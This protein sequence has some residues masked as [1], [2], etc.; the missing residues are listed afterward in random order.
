MRTKLNG[1]LTLL[2]ALIVHITYAQEKTVSGTVTDQS[3]LP[4]PG[5]NIVVQGTT[6]GTQSDFDGNYSITASVG[7]NLLFTYIGQRPVTQTVGASSTINVQMEEDAQALEEVVVVAQNIKREA[8]SL[9]Y[10]VS[11]VGSEQIEDRAQG[12]I[13][14]I[15]Q[16]KAAGVNITATNGV[17]GSGTN[18]IIRGYTSISGSNQPLFIVDGVPFDGGANEQS[19]FFDSAGESSRF[20][21]LDP[22]SIEN[23]KVLKGLSATVLYGER[24][25]NGVVLIT[26]KGGSSKATAEKLEVSV[27]SSYFISNAILPKFQK[28]YG[29][30]FHQAFGFFFS[31]WGPDFAD[32]RQFPYGSNFRGIADD[33][34]VLVRHP[35]SAINDNTLTAEFQDLAA[36]DYR[37]QNYNS[38][39]EFFRTGGVSTNSVNLRGSSDNATYNV[40]LGHLE[41]K[42]F[43]PG[44]KVI[45]NNISLGG[46]ANLSNKITVSGTLNYANTDYRT[47]PISA[48]AGSGTVGDGSSVFGDVMYTPRGVDLFGLPFQTSTGRSIYYRSGNDIQNPRW[49]LAN[50]KTSQ[51]TERIYGNLSFNYQISDVLGLSYQL[52]L[53]TYTELGTY[54]QNKGGVDGDP[55]GIF[56]TT[57]VKN[58][59]WNHTINLTYDKD[60]SED[61]SLQTVLGAQ[62]RNDTF[63]RDGVES[64]QQLAFGVLRHFNFVNHATVNSFTGNEIA[65]LSEENQMGIYGDVTLGY[66][67]GLFLNL[68]ARNDWSSTLERDNYSIFY[69]AA[70][71]S[72]IP[73]KFIEGMVSDNF[74]SSLKMRVGYG[75]SA[76]FPDVYGT[77]NQLSLSSRAFVNQG[78]TVL[79]SNSVANR[80]GN[81]NL[82]AET[83]SEIEAGIDAQFFR[84][85]L[86]LNVSVY[87]KTSEDLITDQNLDPSTG[88]EVTRINAGSLE[89]KGIEVD[90]DFTPISTQDFRWNLSGNF[91]ADESLVTA[92]PEGT[93]QIVLTSSIG[94][95]PANYAV[96]GQPFGVLQGRATLR[97]DAGNRIVGGDG[98]YLVGNDIE[99][100]GDPNPDWNA[101]LTTSFTYKGLSLSANILYRHGGDI[102]SQTAST[103]L[104]RGTVAVAGVDREATYILPGVLENGDPN[105][106]QVTATNVGFDII[107][108]SDGND[109]QIYDGTTLRLNEV[110]IGYAMPQKWLDKT[111]FGKLSFTLSGNNIWYK[112]FN[113]PDDVRFDTNT[114]STGVG[115]G[116]GIDYITGPSSRRYGLSINA[117]F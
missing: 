45:R 75:T 55:N 77:R 19:D 72:F 88:F 15:L 61:F 69:P 9:G 21:D 22:N 110:S 27:N 97:D 28:Q 23:V 37:Y 16:G 20:L 63:D 112:A 67:E 35:F 90:F 93:D 91:F 57:T 34:T 36:S 30:G 41:D 116:Q 105:N 73:T 111:P 40:N 5:V 39:Q 25:R 103:L 64:T 46:S 52:G 81:P 43:T 85:R 24:G 74:L 47:P 3:G 92:L 6:T 48:S 86:S 99:I 78:G 71:V 12:D 95:R 7:Q 51:N 101:G 29:G 70:S 106:I 96:E 1:L 10:A 83:V 114:L 66:K 42:G 104:G 26:T 100:I 82:K 108:F 2:L 102:F 84:N 76:G 87:K 13:G 113:F 94:G 49:T 109:L 117:T 8:G 58:K 33:G 32:Q 50:A 115:N 31:N 89:T 79:S 17:S 62:S 4:L 68:A 14:R 60:L 11:D 107:G 54:G 44:N 56:R 53:D 18:F 65:F 80:L 38:V 98:L 59:I